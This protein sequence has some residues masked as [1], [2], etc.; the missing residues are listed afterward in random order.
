MT[1]I[2]RKSRISLPSAQ[3]LASTEAKATEAESVA[4]AAPD[5]T[6]GASEGSSLSV[7]LPGAQT[8]FK[9]DTRQVS[10]SERP[11]GATARKRSKA[12]VFKR[13]DARGDS[14]QGRNAGAEGAQGTAEVFRKTG[15]PSSDSV[16]LI[17]AH[18]GLLGLKEKKLGQALAEMARVD[19]AGNR[20]LIEET[21]DQLQKHKAFGGDDKGQVA[22]HFVQS[23]SDADLRT[24]RSTPEGQ[25][26]LQ[27]VHDSMRRNGISVQEAKELPRLEGAGIVTPTPQQVQEIRDLIEAGK[28][29]EA[30]DKTIQ[31]YGID[32]R[33]AAVRYDPSLKRVGE[34]SLAGSSDDPAPVAI[35]NKAFK[36]PA[37]LASTIAHESEA[38]VNKQIER[39]RWYTG[40]IGRALQE[41]QAYDHEI[42]MARRSG[43]SD[44]ELREVVSTR[45]Y[46]YNQL[47][48]EYKKRA[49]ARNYEMKPGEENR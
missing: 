17:E 19:P 16:S 31:Y 8:S 27:T 49:D 5:A 21:F 26:I 14:A 11:V 48:D 43:L 13:T 25:Q 37:L 7:S 15:N 45:K 28:K 1:S 38:H 46:F 36:S 44:A 24:L 40:P 18:K 4:G 32:V 33:K 3:S 2:D 30:I 41:V 39:G 35:G 9:A 23:L 22:A 29:Q 12:D 34:T 42:A 47:S 10:S 20:R 6:G